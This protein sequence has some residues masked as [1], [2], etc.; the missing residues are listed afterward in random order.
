M[1]AREDKERPEDGEDSRQEYEKPRLR[2][3]ELPLEET[4]AVGCKI[5]GDFTCEST[6]EAGT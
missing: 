5:G 2:V 1:I 4:M 3:I 6:I